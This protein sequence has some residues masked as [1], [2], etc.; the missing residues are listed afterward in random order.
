M[1]LELVSCAVVRFPTGFGGEHTDEVLRTPIRGRMQQRHQATA[2][3]NRLA[4]PHD[5]LV[6]AKS[7]VVVARAV[8]GCAVG[9]VGSG[10]GEDEE[11]GVGGAGDEGE[12]GGVGEAIDVVDGEGGGEA[13]VVQEGGHDFGVAF[14][15]LVSEDV[16]GG[17]GSGEG[18]EVPNGMNIFLGVLVE[19][20]PVGVRSAILEVGC[21]GNCVIVGGV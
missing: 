3:S 21:V 17:I 19:G 9:L 15:R 18:G 14:C 6:G 2:I 4:K 20:L 13:K 1:G 12:E 7:C 10:G 5:G 11:E 16:D 8:F